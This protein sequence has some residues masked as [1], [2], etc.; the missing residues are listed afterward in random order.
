M[1]NVKHGGVY[2]TNAKRER[3]ERDAAARNAALVD[4]LRYG[5]A[6]ERE[7]LLA[8][9]QVFRARGA[10]LTALQAMAAASYKTLSA[11]ARRR[12]DR[13]VKFCRALE[14]L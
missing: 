1:S 6:E 11:P 2:E 10:R 7:C 14:S 13:V 12:V 4:A 8:M 3:R 9:Q 5:E